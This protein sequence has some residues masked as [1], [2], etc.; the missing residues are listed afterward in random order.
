MKFLKT[1]LHKNLSNKRAILE[2]QLIDIPVLHLVFL[3]LFA[4]NSMC[5]FSTE[6]KLKFVQH[7]RA[8]NGP[9]SSVGIATACGLDGSGIESRW[10]RDFPHLS[11]PAL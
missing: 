6:Q 10:G 5:M 1:T 3:G 8:R 4:L 2:N 9:G 7:Y 11:R